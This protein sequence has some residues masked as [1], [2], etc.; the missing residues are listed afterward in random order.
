MNGRHV[1]GVRSGADV[2]SSSKLSRS[3]EKAKATT[4]GDVSGHRRLGSRT[5]RKFM[6]PEDVTEEVLEA[7]RAALLAEKQAQLAKV[8]DRHD[9][10]VCG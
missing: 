3:R 1:A 4:N 10:M 5:T 8:F 2:G 9:D 7:E 6:R